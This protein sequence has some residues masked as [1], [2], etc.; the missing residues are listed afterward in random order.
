[1]KPNAPVPTDKELQELWQELY[2]EPGA[3]NHPMIYRF[4]RLVLERWGNVIQV[5]GECPQDS[6]GGSEYS[7]LSDW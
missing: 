3:C 6:E 2:W 1:M 4:A 5:V 7:P